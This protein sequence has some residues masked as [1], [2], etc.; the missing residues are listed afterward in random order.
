M[1][2]SLPIFAL[3][4]ALALGACQKPDVVVMPTTPVAVP[5]PAGATGATGN[6]GATGTQGNDGNTGATGKTGGG[7]TVVVVPGAPAS[8]P[9][10]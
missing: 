10:N 5:G 7:T 3:F 4:S 1:N 6:T 2:H 8:A 9:A